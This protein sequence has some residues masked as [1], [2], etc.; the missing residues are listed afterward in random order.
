M[1]PKN[2]R[3]ETESFSENKE[4]HG[5]G[6]HPNSGANLRPFKKGQSGNPGGS[7]LNMLSFVKPL[8]NG[9][10]S[11]SIMIIGMHHQNNVKL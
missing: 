5:L 10:I 4:S 11:K 1:S 2:K 3:L 9:K 8:I 6:D 7:R